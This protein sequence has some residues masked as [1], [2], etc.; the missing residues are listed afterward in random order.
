MRIKLQSIIPIV[1]PSAKTLTGLTLTLL[2]K[3]A[4]L[5]KEF[6]ILLGMKDLELGSKFKVFRWFYVEVF[7]KG[8]YSPII[9]IEDSNCF[10]AYCCGYLV[11]YSCCILKERK[12]SG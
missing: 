11:G 3:F 9:F 8:V 6:A 12:I 1:C 4:D 7:F 5:T 10:I 2:Y